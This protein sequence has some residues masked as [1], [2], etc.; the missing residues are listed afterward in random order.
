MQLG[1]VRDGKTNYRQTACN[2]ARKK[3]FK[4]NSGIMQISLCFTEK[5]GAEQQYPEGDQDI[6]SSRK[7]LEFGFLFDDEAGIGA[8]VGKTGLGETAEWVLRFRERARTLVVKEVR[9]NTVEIAQWPPN[10]SIIPVLGTSGGQLGLVKLRFGS[11]GSPLRRKLCVLQ[12]DPWPGIAKGKVEPSEGSNVQFTDTDTGEYS[13]AGT[14]NFAL[15]EFLASKVVVNS[16]LLEQIGTPD[17]R[18]QLVCGQNCSSLQ[19]GYKAQWVIVL[20]NRVTPERTQKEK[21]ESD[22]GMVT[23][24]NGEAL[25]RLAPSG[26]AASAST[27]SS[28]RATATTSSPPWGVV[29]DDNAILIAIEA[30][31]LPKTP[32]GMKPLA[33][34]NKK[35]DDIE[36]LAIEDKKHDTKDATNNEIDQGPTEDMDIKDTIERDDT[37]KADDSSS[38]SSDS[39]SSSL[40][41]V[42]MKQIALN[43]YTQLWTSDWAD[44]WNSS[45]YVL[46]SSG[47]IAKK[48]RIAYKMLLSLEKA[49][50]EW[51]TDEPQYLPDITPYPRYG[52]P[53]DD[54]STAQKQPLGLG[55]TLKYANK[56]F[57]KL[58]QDSSRGFKA[59]DP[60]REPNKARHQRS[61]V[62]KLKD[63]P[64]LTFT[65]L[66]GRKGMPSPQIKPANGPVACGNDEAVVLAAKVLDSYSEAGFLGSL[67][68]TKCFDCLRPDA[69]AQMPTLTA[70]SKLWATIKN[71]LVLPSLSFVNGFGFQELRPWTWTKEGGP[72]GVELSA[73]RGLDK[74]TASVKAGASGAGTGLPS[75]V[76]ASAGSYLGIQVEPRPLSLCLGYAAPLRHSYRASSSPRGRQL[77]IKSATFKQPMLSFVDAF[78]RPLL[79]GNVYDVLTRVRNFLQESHFKV[80]T[81]GNRQAHGSPMGSPLSPALCGM[82]VAAQEE[83]W[84][85]TFRQ[86]CLGMNRSLLCVRYVD[87]RLWIPEPA[88]VTLPEVAA[89]WIPRHTMAHL[90]LQQTE[91]CE[92]ISRALLE[93]LQ[94]AEPS[95]EAVEG[96][97]QRLELLLSMANM[98]SVERVGSFLTCLE[99]LLDVTDWTPLRL[100]LTSSGSGAG[101]P[102]PNSCDPCKK[103]SWTAAQSCYHLTLRSQAGQHSHNV[104]VMPMLALAKRNI[105]IN[106][107]DVAKLSGRVDKKFNWLKSAGLERIYMD[108]GRLQHMIYMD[109]E[110][111]PFM[112]VA[113]Y[114]TSSRTLGGDIAVASVQF[115]DDDFHE[116]SIGGFV[117]EFQLYL[118]EDALGTN[119]RMIDSVGASRSSYEITNAFRI[120]G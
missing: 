29:R 118:A 60:P 42:G 30:K 114:D 49:K 36:K 106:T 23:F 102:T 46:E 37:G 11:I 93:I 110:R 105:S 41:E 45:L 3:E 63:G 26:Q 9:H 96:G 66:L 74:A 109:I 39:S 112:Q 4:L 64:L 101:L 19:F 7:S 82:V 33:I 58:K 81:R 91:R 100:P 72:R 43:T 1:P 107:R 61:V 15:I 70:S 47:D 65:L 98:M 56:Y 80:C 69:T 116:N 40:S 113:L 31:R 34:D 25:L 13:L 104:W 35:T 73:G 117:S 55:V 57:S 18:L 78:M 24:E 103:Y 87:N 59:P 22:K 48:R 111:L 5:N 2:C 71:G 97:L 86:T 38:S 16:L 32:D 44:A 54:K 20:T 51:D 90:L 52:L 77:N 92:R 79:E 120:G 6:A 85:R 21:R 119:E 28:A 14:D 62:F 8:W 88:I 89:A 53:G 10:R 108:I 115:T 75:R 50:L 17:W 95:N 94:D 99:L 84:Q 83:I 68:Y 76:M 27:T 12:K 67:D